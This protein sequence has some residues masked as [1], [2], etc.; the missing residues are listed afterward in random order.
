MA[1]TLALS[2]RERESGVRFFGTK[3]LEICSRYLLT[4]TAVKNMERDNLL[5]LYLRERGWGEG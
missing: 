4:L 3:P 5:P 1:L 2:L